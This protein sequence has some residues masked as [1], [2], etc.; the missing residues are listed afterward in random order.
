MY[1]LGAMMQGLWGMAIGGGFTAA[2]L[3][4]Y[5]LARLTDGSS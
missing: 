1:V 5:W 2:A 3:L 4:F